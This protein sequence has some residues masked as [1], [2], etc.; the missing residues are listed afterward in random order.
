M[1][2]VQLAIDWLWLVIALPLGG[3][4]LLQVLGRRIGEPRAG[5]I[6]T[7]LVGAAFVVAA[8]ASVDVLTG[9]SPHHPVYLFTWIPALGLDASLLWDPLST[10]MTLV[11]IGVGFLIHLYSVGYM[12]GEARFGRFFA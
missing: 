9:E 7:L 5:W 4:V 3:Y 6:A 11:V 2:P 10:M 1:D 8:V 12:H